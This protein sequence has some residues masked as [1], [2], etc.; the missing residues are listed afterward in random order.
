MIKRVIALQ[1]IFYPFIFFIIVWGSFQ[2]SIIESPSATATRLQKAIQSTSVLAENNQT[3]RETENNPTSK[4]IL[5]NQTIPAQTTSQQSKN[6]QVGLPS[7]T[8]IIS[9]PPPQPHLCPPLGNWNPIFIQPGDTIFNIAR[10]SS[11]STKQLAEANCLDGENVS[12]GTILYVPPLPSP[13]PLTTTTCAPPTGWVLYT[14]QSGNT[15][16]QISFLVNLPLTQLLNANCLKQ[17]TLLY[18]GQK[19]YIPF[20]LLQVGTQTKQPYIFFTITPLTETLPTNTFVPTA[21]TPLPYSTITP[22]LIQTV[23]R[24]YTQI[25]TNYPT[26]FNLITPTS[27]FQQNSSPQKT[28]KP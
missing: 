4:A 13:Q 9:A 24:Y 15:L 17:D 11:I 7:R 8:T 27:L 14:V 10:K 21:S 18:I 25:P 26:L 6:T 28:S 2:V 12:P 23:P 5:L 16:S 3:Q 19:I 22:I 20:A 1:V